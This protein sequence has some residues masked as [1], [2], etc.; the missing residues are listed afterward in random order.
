MRSTH[1]PASS[2]RPAP[3]AGVVERLNREIAAALASPPVQAHLAATGAQSS[4]GSPA[5]FARFVQEEWERYG[6]LLQG[7]DLQAE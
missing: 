1:G 4:A 2:H 7:M 3:P 5:Q 6:K